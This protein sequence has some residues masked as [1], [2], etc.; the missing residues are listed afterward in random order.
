MDVG[1]ELIDDKVQ[2]PINNIMRCGIF[3]GLLSFSLLLIDLA[4]YN[5]PVL[6]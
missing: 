4:R 5:G 2:K 3:L 6:V 1:E